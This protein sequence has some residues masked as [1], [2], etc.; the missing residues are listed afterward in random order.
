M[1]CKGWQ[2]KGT[3]RHGSLQEGHGSSEPQA[4]EASMPTPA[5]SGRHM[6]VLAVLASNTGNGVDGMGMPADRRWRWGRQGAAE[7]LCCSRHTTFLFASSFRQNRWRLHAQSS[8]TC[9]GRIGPPGHPHP[10]RSTQPCTNTALHS[11]G[12][13]AAACCAC[14]AYG[15]KLDSTCFGGLAQVQRP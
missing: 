2:L 3:T 7:Q 13:Y 6:P 4:L 9:L 12:L 11:P 1:A 14:R 5:S 15:A 8:H 10:T